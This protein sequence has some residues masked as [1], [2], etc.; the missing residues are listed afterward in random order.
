MTIHEPSALVEAFASL[1]RA[2][3]AHMSDEA[4]Q[5]ELDARQLLWEYVES[6]WQDVERAGERPEVG[7]KYHALAVV[8]SRLFDFRRAPSGSSLTIGG[9]AGCSATVPGAGSCPG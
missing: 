5:Q 1:D 7:D 2:R 8:H 9:C 3:L 4:R 6:L